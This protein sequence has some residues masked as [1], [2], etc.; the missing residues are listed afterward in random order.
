[1]YR[2]M[3]PGDTPMLLP[4]LYRVADLDG[5]PCPTFT[6][7][8]MEARGIMRFIH[9]SRLRQPVVVD[10]EG[11]RAWLDASLPLP[12]ARDVALAREQSGLF[13]PDPPDPRLTASPPDRDLPG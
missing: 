10:E 2:L 7:C 13:V 11:A 4:G 5:T 6:V 12:A 1:M 9:N 8:T 3:L